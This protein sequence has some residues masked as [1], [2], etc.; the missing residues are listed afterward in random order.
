MNEGQEAKFKDCPPRPVADDILI[1]QLGIGQEISCEC[2]C[3]K[4]I[5]RE[6]AKWS[7]VATASYRLLPHIQLKKPIK[8]AVAEQLKRTCPVGVF[9]I[10]DLAGGG[11]QAV[12]ANP[13]RCTT[14][15]ECLESFDADAHG[16]V[17]GKIKDHYL[18]TVESTGCLP[19]AD[20]LVRAVEKLSDKC[21]VAKTVLE[22][23]LQ[24]QPH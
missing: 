16:L 5:G 11:K 19:A 7:P 10:E 17:L 15:R 22:G 21:Q 18:F 13:R 20:L 23:R 24:T 6:H 12:V 2:Q 3:E 4:N 1:T 14:C 9:D 8:D